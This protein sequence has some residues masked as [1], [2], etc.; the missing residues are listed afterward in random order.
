MESLWQINQVHNRNHNFAINDV[1]DKTMKKKMF[2]PVRSSNKNDFNQAVRSDAP[3][4]L[5]WH[6]RVMAAIRRIGQLRKHSSMN[7]E[8]TG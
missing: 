4:P 8:I 7:D 5:C 6:E 2:N 3:I 1:R